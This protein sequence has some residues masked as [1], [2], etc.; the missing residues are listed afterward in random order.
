VWTLRE[1]TV[2]GE[3]IRVCRHIGYGNF[4]ASD[5]PIVLQVFRRCG[6]VK[7]WLQATTI[8]TQKSSP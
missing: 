3:I 5:E 4:G 8:I 1:V 6:A 2:I 7:G